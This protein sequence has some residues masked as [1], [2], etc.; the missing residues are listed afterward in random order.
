MQEMLL[1]IIDELQKLGVLCTEGTTLVQTGSPGACATERVTLILKNERRIGWLK[2]E[3]TEL[4][5]ISATRCMPTNQS[6]PKREY[7]M[8]HGKLSVDIAHPDSIE[9]LLQF[10]GEM[11]Q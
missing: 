2:L 6:E 1:V 5:I 7:D 3:G 8:L 9:L 11:V 4:F 10:V